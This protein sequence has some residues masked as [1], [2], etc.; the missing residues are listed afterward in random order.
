M[1]RVTITSTGERDLV[2]RLQL[3]PTPAGLVTPNE[4]R[5]RLDIKYSVVGDVSL[6]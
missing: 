5:Y 1:P 4:V 2:P 3:V 6:I